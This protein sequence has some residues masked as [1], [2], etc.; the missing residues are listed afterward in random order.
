M[1]DAHLSEILLSSSKKGTK[2]HHLLTCK[3]EVGRCIT[4]SFHEPLCKSA[5][6]SQTVLLWTLQAGVK[7]SCRKGA[8]NHRTPRPASTIRLLLWILQ[9]GVKSSCRKGAATH[10]T[11]RPKFHHVNCQLQPRYLPIL[12]SVLPQAPRKPRQSSLLLSHAS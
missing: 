6:V 1:C 8:A 2:S 12:P 7:N 9:A 5:G 10:R 4:L 11:P 3:N